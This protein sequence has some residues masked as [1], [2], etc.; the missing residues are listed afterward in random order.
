VITGEV[1]AGKTVAVRAALAGLD[2][3]RHTVIYLP[4]PTVGVRGINH[5]IR[6]R[7]AV[8]KTSAPAGV[9]EGG[10]PHDGVPRPAVIVHPLAVRLELL[11]VVTGPLV[12]AVAVPAQLVWLVVVAVCAV[13]VERRTAPASPE[14]AVEAGPR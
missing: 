7:A 4:N 2:P 14:T 13:V 11:V 5:Q 9:M 6:T 8:S 3:T 1:G 10:V 12:L